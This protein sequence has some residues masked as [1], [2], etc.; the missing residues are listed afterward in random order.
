[1]GKLVSKLHKNFM[2]KNSI[3]GNPFLEISSQTGIFAWT[4]LAAVSWRISDARYLLEAY[5][6]TF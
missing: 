3:M 2:S 6:G 5:N 1:M 4:S